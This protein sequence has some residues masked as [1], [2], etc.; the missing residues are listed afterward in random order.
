MYVSYSISLFLILFFKPNTHNLFLFSSSIS[1]QLILNSATILDIAPENLPVHQIHAVG[2]AL[3]SDSP[4]VT[5]AGVQFESV[6]TDYFSKEKS[7]E[8]TVTFFHP[9]GSRF[10]NQT[11][12]MKRG[13]F[14]FF[15]GSLSS[16]E[17]KFY[18]ELHG[19][20]FLRHQSSSVLNHQPK[21]PWTK[22]LKTSTIICENQVESSDTPS[23]VLTNATPDISSDVL[24]NATPN[25]SSNTPS[26]MSQSP[27]LHRSPI[28]KA[29]AIHQQP[30]PPVS[31][32]RKTRSSFKA[33]KMP[34]LADIATNALTN[35]Q[36][37]V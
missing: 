11:T 21:M 26:N 23:D 4:T 12:A 33:S 18:L 24:T 32:K 6:I 22:N 13:S 19:F 8:T 35:T 3:V 9:I 20:S 10:T 34:K 16:I 1:H 37:E 2:V 5:D 29:R 27:D 17:G 30:T 15:T 31:S 14:I 28:R 25:T 36:E 7:T